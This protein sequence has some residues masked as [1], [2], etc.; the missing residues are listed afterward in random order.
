MIKNWIRI[1]YIQFAKWGSSEWVRYGKTLDDSK[2]PRISITGSKYLSP[3]KDN[4]TIKIYNLPYSEILKIQIEELFH[5]Q[6]YAGYLGNQAINQFEAKKIFDGGIVNILNEKKEYKDN[7]ATFVCA[8]ELMAKAQQWRCNITFNS[9]IN[10]YTAVKTMNRMAGMQNANISDS[11]KAKFMTQYSS[12][13]SSPSSYLDKISSTN[14]TYFM[15]S[16]TSSN[17]SSL[18]FWDS[19]RGGMPKIKIDPNLGMMIGSAPEITSNGLS[20]SSLPVY[21]YTPGALCEI[22]NSYI[23]VTSGRTSYE[24]AIQTPNTVYLDKQ[25]LYYIYQLDYTLD[26]TTGDFLINITAKAKDLFDNV[27]GSTNTTNG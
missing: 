8:S 16:D 4:F 24:G 21:N 17:G 1:L 23:N 19:I 22:D 26:N 18:N 10:L 27:T 3:V 14:N 12:A 15:N 11:Y 2:K 7:I 20:W 6:I 5:V 25:G 9:G 13:S